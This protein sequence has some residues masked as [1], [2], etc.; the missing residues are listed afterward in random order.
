MDSLSF[1]PLASPGNDP[2]LHVEWE[3][4][5]LGTSTSAR[6]TISCTM[7]HLL[8]VRLEQGS[9][10]RTLQASGRVVLPVV[11]IATAGTGGRVSARDDVTGATAT[12]TWT[13]RSDAPLHAH[14]QRQPGLWQTVKQLFGSSPA[15][16]EAAVHEG[17]AL[18]RAALEQAV[19][20]GPPV[21]DPP[22]DGD[23]EYRGPSKRWA[24]RIQGDRGTALVTNAP[25]VYAPGDTILFIEQRDATS[26]VGRT[27]YTDGQYRRVRC[28]L[29]GRDRIQCALIVRDGS[30]AEYQLH[31]QPR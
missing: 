19:P 13:W 6:C 10:V 17:V 1:E 27:I 15:R 21:P 14:A 3:T 31:R 22:V 4:V 29:A 24:L 18:E 30:E 25:H 20:S 16:A 8:T 9:Y 2:T 7:P 23:W 11:P 26:F 28:V 5:P 12:V